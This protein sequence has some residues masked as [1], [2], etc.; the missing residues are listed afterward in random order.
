[1]FRT[2]AHTHHNNNKDCL[3]PL[4]N[5]TSGSQDSTKRS[6]PT[7]MMKIKID[8]DGLYGFNDVTVGHW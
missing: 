3:S 7:P 1:M 2:P 5:A 6:G 4:W 8:D